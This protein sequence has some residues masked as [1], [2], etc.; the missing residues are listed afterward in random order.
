MCSNSMDADSRLRRRSVV[1]SVFICEA[2]AMDE[3]ARAHRGCDGEVV[4][5]FRVGRTRKVINGVSM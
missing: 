2:K 3:I 4:F 5:R 1:I